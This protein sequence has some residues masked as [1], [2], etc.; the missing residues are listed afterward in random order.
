MSDGGFW[1]ECINLDAVC[2]PYPAG[3]KNCSKPLVETGETHG[4][5]AM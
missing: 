2:F 4:G 5:A 3:D 1:E